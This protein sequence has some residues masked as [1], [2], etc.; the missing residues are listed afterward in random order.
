MDIGEELRVIDVDE[1]H[2]APLEI[3]PVMAEEGAK[4]PEETGTQTA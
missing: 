4:E 1:P 2:A 3:E